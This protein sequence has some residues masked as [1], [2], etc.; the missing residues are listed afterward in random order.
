MTDCTL[1]ETDVSNAEE[2]VEALKPMLVATNIMC[3]EKCPTI[4]I[5]APLHAQLLRDTSSTTEDSPLVREIKAAINQDLSKRYQSVKEKELLYL[6]SALDPR[7]KSLLFMSPQEMQ[8]TYSK[9][10]L[11]AT[12]LKEDAE[13]PLELPHTET[14]NNEVTPPSPKKR[15]S[16]LVNLL[17]QTFEKD[18]TFFSAS[19]SIAEREIK[20][21]QDAPSLPL[22]EEDPLLWWKSQAHVY[23]LLAK[24]AQQH[25]CIPGTSVPAERIFSTAGDIISIQRSSLTSDHADQ[26]IFLKKNMVI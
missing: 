16:A 10:V 9:L 12:A 22:T 20:Q 23:P 5:I 19:T 15:K 18:A 1:T 14:E 6:S 11:K 8:D 2:M 3:E 4:S 21:Y 13:V 7:F 26:L 17:G 25:L 24:L